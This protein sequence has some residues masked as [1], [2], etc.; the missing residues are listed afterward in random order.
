MWEGAMRKSE[1]P[2]EADVLDA[3]KTSAWPDCCGGD[4]RAHVDDCM[5]CRE[6]VDVV[7]PLLHEHQTAVADARVPSSAIVWWRAQLRAR[8]EAAA[9]AGRPITVV[10]GLS[11][12]CAAGLLAAMTGYVF[13]AFRQALTSL[14]AMISGMAWT[15][16]PVVAWPAA[17]LHT[18]VGVVALLAITILLVLAPVAIYLAVTEE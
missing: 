15:E 18:P 14:W 7:L 6:V 2:R 17:G 9:V 10:Q 16:L 5:A 4:L 13:P 1:C 12:A 8:Q 3:L 11:I